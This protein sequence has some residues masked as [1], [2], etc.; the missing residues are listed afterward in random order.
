MTLQ[1]YKTKTIDLTDS[2]ESPKTVIFYV[3]L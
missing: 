1:L 2:G 3:I